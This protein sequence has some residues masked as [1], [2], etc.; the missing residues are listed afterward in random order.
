[1]ARVY[2]VI[3]GVLRTSTWLLQE[4]I[5]RRWLHSLQA[6]PSETAPEDNQVLCIIHRYIKTNIDTS[7]SSEAC[8]SRLSD[9]HCMRDERNCSLII[10]TSQFNNTIIIIIAEADVAVLAACCK[11]KRTRRQHNANIPFRSPKHRRDCTGILCKPMCHVSSVFGIACLN[12][13]H[14]KEMV[15]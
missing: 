5:L 2:R 11:W 15:V 9:C 10:S 3:D 14:L 6:P 13:R 8:T 1:M 4:P 12:R 7:F